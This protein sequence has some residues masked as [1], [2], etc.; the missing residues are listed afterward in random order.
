[1]DSSATINN[2]VFGLFVLGALSLLSFIPPADA[3][4]NKMREVRGDP[5]NGAYV[6]RA[7][8]CNSCHLGKDKG[9]KSGLSG[10]EEFKTP[11]G[12]FYAPNVSMSEKYGIGKWTYSDFY[13]SLKSGVN[14]EG[15]HYYPAFPYT[16]YSKI[17]EED[18]ADLWAFW[19]TLPAVEIPSKPHDIKFPFNYR[20][21]LGIWKTLFW[22]KRH[23]V[24]DG[25]ARSTY[26]V[27]A[28]GHCAECHTSRNQFG[29]LNR[30]KWMRGGSNPSGKGNIPSIHPK[31]LKWSKKDIIEYLTT[32]LTPEFDVAGGQMVSVIKN[33][34]KLTLEDKT[35]IA[36]YLFNLR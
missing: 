14:P 18:I 5:K 33:T 34:S 9:L 29:A 31:D 22:D 25:R 12:I 26:L 30:D 36:E 15:K 28:L 4:Q 19:Q 32:G 23:V 24:G 1:M 7:A 21:S 2:L 10:G 3:Q 13:R 27:E 16:S 8:G 20:W 11:F 35:L 17:K 6:F